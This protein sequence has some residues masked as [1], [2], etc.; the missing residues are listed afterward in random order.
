MK[1]ELTPKQLQVLELIWQGKGTQ[2]IAEELGN[3]KRTIDG[4]RHEIL[5]R[6]RTQNTAQLLK[7]ALKNRW[8]KVR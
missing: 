1:V 4:I 5:R 6:T 3:T 8:I 7:F 2:E